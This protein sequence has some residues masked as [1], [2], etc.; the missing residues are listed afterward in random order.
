MFISRIL[1]LSLFLTL[2]NGY[3]YAQEPN[4]DSAVQE[5]RNDNYEVAAEQFKQLY[6]NDTN[7]ERSAFYLG[8]IYFYAQEFDISNDWFKKAQKFDPESSVYAMWIGRCYGRK[9][10]YSGKIRQAFLA[11][12]T[13]KNF[14]KAIELDPDNLDA[15]ENLITFYVVA[16]S[17]VGG[18]MLKAEEQAAYIQS[19]DSIRGYLAYATIY[20][21][22][23]EPKKFRAK[24]EE[25]ITE[26]PDDP[27]LYYQLIGL[28]IREMKYDEAHSLVDKIIPLDT[29]QTNPLYSRANIYMASQDFELAVPVYEQIT[30]L[31]PDEFY[32]HYQIGRIASQHGIELEKGIENL[33]TVIDHPQV[34]DP[35][36]VTWSYYR[37]GKIREMK[38][39]KDEAR[40][41]YEEALKLDKDHKEAAQALKELE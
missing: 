18:S 20:N 30:E 38:N 12:K 10:Q 26:H 29:I 33:N 13:K 9:A 6:K 31:N 3:L 5:F 19:K 17:I 41:M 1:A 23:N 22:K 32:A 15:R 36:L 24:M 11:G 35:N 37:I 7:A 25:G 27:R 21:D 28:N 14:M 2:F 4:F 16:P 40:K 34:S 8:R 39:Q